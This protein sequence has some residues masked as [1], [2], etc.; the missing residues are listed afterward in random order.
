MENRL[1][2]AGGTRCYE[3]ATEGVLLVMEL[4][5]VLSVAV[6]TKNYML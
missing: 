6:D 1:V 4:F 3:R 5:C 2:V